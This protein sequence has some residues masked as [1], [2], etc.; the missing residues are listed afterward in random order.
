MSEWPSEL[1]P[2]E[3]MAEYFKG[4]SEEELDQVLA[5]LEVELARTDTLDGFEA[6][7]KIIHGNE[8][9]KHC[10]AWVAHMMLAHGES[11]GALIWAW[12]GSWKTTT[13]SVTFTAWRIGLEPERA[14]LVIQANDDSAN[15]VCKGITDIIAHH[16]GWKIV[17][18][19]VVPD[20]GKGWGESGYEVKDKRYSESE[21]SER[22]SARKDPT[23]LGL[24]IRS[25][26]LI[27]KHPDGVLLL[28][29]I[30]DEENTASD[31]ENENVINKVKGTILPFIVEDNESMITW[32]IAVGTPWR[33]DD[34]YHYLRDTNEFSFFKL[35]VMVR[36][37]EYG[38]NPGEGETSYDGTEFND[39]AGVWRLTW[40]ERFGWGIVQRWRRRAGKRDFFRMFLL[41]LVG[42][43]D[44]GI[45]YQSYPAEAIS[46]SWVMNGA[47]DFAS[48]REVVQKNDKS[49]AFFTMLIGA[50]IPTGGAVIIGGHIG[51]YTISESLQKIEQTQSTF[52]NYN[53]TAIEETGKGEVFVD[54]LLLKPHLR[55]QPV[56]VGGIPKWRRQE[57][58]APWLENGL[59]RISNADSPVLNTL[60]KALDE[61]P[62]GNNDVRDAVWVLIKTMPDVFHI[63]SLPGEVQESIYNRSKK[64]AHPFKVL[65]KMRG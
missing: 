43:H 8:L 33:E 45:A 1:P 21:W 15:K 26:S 17:F 4:M 51:R 36:V 11:K 3:A 10:R 47:A 41:D 18:P 29:D 34:A 57:S 13:I 2:R 55:I 12:R 6:F 30:H 31:R 19:D 9:P 42:S 40:P 60:R 14:N 50:K 58:S 56:G 49:R 22:N 64:A 39:L 54:F 32:A 7:Y 61:Y 20:E 16:G 44:T 65:A 62:D 53:V 28:D 24:G 37:G 35:P 27:G 46:M 63:D 38:D 23:L 59:L 48:I 25:K 5:G 52:P